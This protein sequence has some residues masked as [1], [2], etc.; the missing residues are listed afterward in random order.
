M[1]RAASAPWV[2]GLALLGLAGALLAMGCHTGGAGTGSVALLLTDAPSDDFDRVELLV[3]K[4]ELFGASR[5]EIFSGRETVDLLALA[6]FSNPFFVATEVP[7]GA[8]RKLRLTIDDVTLVRE[9]EDARGRTW[10]ESVRVE[11]PGGGVI[12]LVPRGS[13]F[14]VPG[15]TLVMEIDVDAGKA[16]RR[17]ATDGRGYGLRPVAFVRVVEG[18]AELSKPARV[19]G[20]IREF[21]GPEAF[22]LCS[23]EIRATRGVDDRA[24]ST[25]SCLTVNF[26]AETR[27]FGRPGERVPTDELAPGQEV[28]VV[29]AIRVQRGGAAL[30]TKSAR[31]PAAVPFALAELAGADLQLDALAVEVGPEGE[32]FQD[33]VAGL[34]ELR[35]G[36]LSNLDP[37][38][39]RFELSRSAEPGCIAVAPEASLL[40]VADDGQVASASEISLHDLVEGQRVEVFGAA[41]ESCFQAEVIVALAAGRLGP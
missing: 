11:P 16:I 26:G 18:G 5:V 8:Y 30:A 15:D 27:V 37:A 20:S 40:L 23:D 19:H 1:R 7:V 10:Q 3:S 22:S 13:F 35:T 31:A 39:R 25:S 24:A 34:V 21:L 33:A 4:V 9:R 41:A 12:D 29:G 28:T 17:D 38:A 14:V 36:A 32:A 6:S 2:S